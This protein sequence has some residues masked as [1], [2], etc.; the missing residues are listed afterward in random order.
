MTS[1]KAISFAVG[2]LL[3]GTLLS[4]VM[5]GVWFDTAT[6]TV[7]DSLRVIKSYEILGFN[8]PWVNIDFFTVGIPKLFS[9]DFVFFGGQASFFKYVMYVISI[10]MIWGMVAVV[11]GIIANLRSR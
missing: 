1:P 8:V 7:F 2:V 6:K 10:G 11:I 4:F 5:G 9:F 3:I